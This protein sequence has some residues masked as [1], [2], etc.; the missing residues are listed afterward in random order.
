MTPHGHLS[1]TV[2][3]RS[4]WLRCPRPGSW[5]SEATFLL[6]ISSF[7]RSVIVQVR[8]ELSLWPVD[9]A[10]RGGLARMTLHD[11]EISLNSWRQVL[12]RACCTS[13][14]SARRGGTR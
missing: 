8:L 7:P 14:S 2:L 13:G 1:S 9:Q 6:Q 10:Y 12:V 3:R 5:E 11:S 4:H